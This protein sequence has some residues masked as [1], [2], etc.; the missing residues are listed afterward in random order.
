M[1]DRPQEITLIYKQIG[2]FDINLLYAWNQ[3]PEVVKYLPSM[4]KPLAYEQHVE[5]WHRVYPQ[6]RHG[7]D[8]MVLL[9]NGSY[10]RVVGR[11]HASWS[12]VMWTEDGPPSPNGQEI[13]YEHSMPEVGVLL[14][15]PDVWGQG[16]ATE[17]VRRLLD[18]LSI[19]HFK[20]CY[21][22]IHPENTAS[23]RVFA[24]AGFE[25]NSGTLTQFGRGKQ[26]YWTCHIKAPIE[27]TAQRDGVGNLIPFRRDA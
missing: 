13:G 18:I 21:A 12:E 10:R 20:E 9:D 25:A 15:C 17:A 26:R 4:P 5:W 23:Q 24:K 16:I 14:G 6:R 11:I 2:S 1:A 8:R 3:N 7:L 22:L 27:E 19:L